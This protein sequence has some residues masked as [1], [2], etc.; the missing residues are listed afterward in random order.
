MTRVEADKRGLAIDAQQT[1]YDIMHIQKRVV[2]PGD[3]LVKA[4]VRQCDEFVEIESLEKEVEGREEEE[5]KGKLEFE[6]VEPL[7]SLNL[8]HLATALVYPLLVR[9]V[10]GRRGSQV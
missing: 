6:F 4:P 2:A 1:R 7:Q 5:V 8:L 10:L 9:R 3:Y